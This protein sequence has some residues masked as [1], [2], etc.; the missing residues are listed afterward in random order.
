MPCV[1]KRRVEVRTRPVLILAA[2][3]AATVAALPPASVAGHADCSLRLEGPAL[4]AGIY[5]LSYGEIVCGTVKNTIRLRMTMTRDGTT[6]DDVVT[7]CHKDAD[8]WNYVIENDAPGDQLWCT[9][10]SARVGPHNVAPI[11]RCATF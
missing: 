5:A 9:T 11:T 1:S 6:T 10:I 4:D 8:C 2:V 3:V 7:T